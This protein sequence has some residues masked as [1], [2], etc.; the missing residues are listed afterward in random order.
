MLKLGRSVLSLVYC[1]LIKQQVIC[2]G[3]LKEK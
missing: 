3:D 2:V 1:W